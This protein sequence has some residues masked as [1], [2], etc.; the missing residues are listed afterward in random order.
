MA[1]ARY[2]RGIILSSWRLLC[3]ARHGPATDREIAGGTKEFLADSIKSRRVPTYRR[4]IGGE[5]RELAAS[6]WRGSACMAGARL[7]MYR[8]RQCKHLCLA[9]LAGYTIVCAELAEG[10]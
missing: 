2:R 1:A 6:G 8:P 3:T 5:K 4:G 10:M 7:G 9:L